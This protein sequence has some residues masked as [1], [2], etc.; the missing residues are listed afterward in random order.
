MKKTVY[1]LL[2]TVFLGILSQCGNGPAEAETPPGRNMFG[3]YV[4]RGLL[5]TSEGL[6]P[7]YAMYAVTNS[8]STYLV[9][10]DGKVVHEW[11]ATFSAFNPYLMNDG[12][13]IVGVDDPDFA[14][15]NDTGPYGRIQHLSW[16]GKIL[17]SYELANDSLILHHDI[18]IKPNGNILAIVYEAISYEKA[19]ALGRDPS[20]TPL[21]G[22]W[23]E[24]IIE[25]VPEGER[26]GKIVWEWNLE[27]HLIQD[28]DETKMNYGDP[29]R[30]PEL[31]DFNVGHPVPAPISLDSLEA[32]RASG[33]AARNQSQ[34]NMG[35]DLYHFNAIN[36]NPELEQIVLSS[37]ALSEIYILDQSTTTEEAASHHG[38]KSGRGGDFLYRWGNPQNYRHGDS[39]DQQLN[40]QH[41]VR[42]IEPGKPGAGHLTVF[43]NN[44]PN[45]PDSLNYTS[46]FE[47]V[48]PLQGDGT[49]IADSDGRYGPE[50][51]VWKYIA[52]DT[53]SF[54]ASFISGAHRME[55]GNTFINAGPAARFFEVTPEGEI[56]W[57]Y[58]NPYRGQIR[59]LNGD[60]I[61]FIPFVYW[62]FRST[63]IPADHPALAGKE[64]KPL[65]PQPEP[66]VMQKPPE[67]EK[68]E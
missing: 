22:P 67:A 52:P 13:L 59:E 46:V 50:A 15:F 53:L 7:G 55:N 49:Y 33:Q 60:P 57:E 31:L 9:D 21:S 61:D 24:K 26:G 18:A 63:F 23:M 11:K 2:L 34:T 25:I 43:N 27:D 6:T 10:R 68:K 3:L 65:D 41:D 19:M 40:G 12:S 4:P 30:H 39:T 66:Y 51:P 48:T 16:D 37:P 14:V 38:G 62:A 64:L 1:Y 47:L 42:W 56:V 44:A 20:L 5:K 36:Y 28:R 29:A 35:S 8:G 17:W 45:V 32:L 54:F 58:W